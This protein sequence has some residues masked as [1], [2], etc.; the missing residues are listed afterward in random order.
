M[1]LTPVFNAAASGDGG[2]TPVDAGPDLTGPGGGGAETASAAAD[3]NAESAP[4]AD[5]Q[6]QFLEMLERERAEPYLQNNSRPNR[7]VERWVHTDI[8]FDRERLISEVRAEL[9]ASE[10]E[11]DLDQG[12]DR[13]EELELRW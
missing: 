5:A 10:Y 12:P 3:F 11:W 9:D 6:R 8:E 13:D 4:N 1:E 2:Q 7:K